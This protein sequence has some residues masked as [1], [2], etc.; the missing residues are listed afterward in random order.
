MENNENSSILLATPPSQIAS[1]QHDR[2]PELEKSDQ[3]SLGK[4][5]NKD[6][7]TENP[8]EDREFN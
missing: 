2:E 8:E 5:Y 4:Q 3:K 6:T 7:E 1:K